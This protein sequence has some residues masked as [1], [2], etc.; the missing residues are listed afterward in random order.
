MKLISQ[1]LYKFSLFVGL[2][3][4]LGSCSSYDQF[5]HITEEFEVPTK[6]YKVE[7]NQAWQAVSD[8][9][10][11]YNLE[12]KSQQSGLIKTRWEDNTLE[13]NF[14]DSF[15]SS[16]TIKGAKFK[17]VVNVIKGF[18]GTREVSKV[19][20]FKRQLIEQDFLQGWKVVPSDGIL[21]KTIL[22]RID[23][24]LRIEKKLKSIEEQRS[25]EAEK[26]LLES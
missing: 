4:V 15:G 5:R 9:M 7:Y 13:L 21:E 22:Y 19:T 24:I 16:D 14:S 2:S 23:R 6:I 1:N 12:V 8:V 3:L 20:V 25:Q 11:K 17:L 26:D 10:K 18:R